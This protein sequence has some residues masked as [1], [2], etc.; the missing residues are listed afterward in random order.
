MKKIC[1]ICLF[2]SLFTVLIF[3]RGGQAN[4]SGSGQATLR[5]SWWGGD[6]RHQATLQV[7]ELY[8]QRNPGVKIEGEYGGWDGYYEKLVTQLAGGTAADVL[9]IDQP[10]L[11]ELSSRGEMF[12][13]LNGI[14]GLDI[15]K[16]DASFIQNYCTYN[17]Q[18]KGL[19]TGLNGET[20]MV[21]TVL[22]QKAGIRINT[23]WDWDLLFTEGKKVTNINS[24]AYLLSFAPDL[25]RYAIFQKYLHQIVGGMIDDNKNIMFTEKQAEDALAIIRSLLD[26]KIL[27][28]FSE[29]TLYS[30]KSEENPDWVNGNL[31][32]IHA[33]ASNHDKTAAGKSNLAVSSL[34]IMKNAIDTGILVRPSQI[35]SVN[36]NSP[37]RDEALKFINFFFNDPEA[38]T[39]LATSR[40]IPPT[41][42]ARGILS[43]KGLIKPLVEE[44]TNIALSRMGEPWSV[45]ES[46]SEITQIMDDVVERVGFGVITPAQGAKDLRDRIAAKLAS[47]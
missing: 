32:L 3:A 40:G 28:P 46:N 23:E 2:F 37:Y 7:I 8:Q 36:N 12:M 16:F 22:L 5:F 1:L 21:D 6:E 17:G 4:T 25:V 10:W 45:W 30:G 43:E 11:Y 20:F 24:Q 13:T 35:L 38:V 39:I 26:Q 14:Q 27:L 31:A 34:P 42:T 44:A 33:W 47:L 19:P 29:S 41:T 15:S 9:Q 18:I